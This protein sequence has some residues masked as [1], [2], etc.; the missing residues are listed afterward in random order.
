[1][2]DVLK[3]PK[4]FYE[5]DKYDHYNRRLNEVYIQKEN[6][7]FI[8]G[9]FA[10]IRAGNVFKLSKDGKLYRALAMCDYDAKLHQA[11]IYCTTLDDYNEENRIALKQYIFDKPV[12]DPCR[13]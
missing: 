13:R 12:D 2:D 3:I 11:I 7:T 8:Q 6:G 1:M 5:I 4:E 10:L 9:R